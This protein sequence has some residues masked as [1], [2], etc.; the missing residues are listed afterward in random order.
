MITGKEHAQVAQPPTGWQT[1]ADIVFRGVAHLFGAA[2]VLLL[3]AIVFE[4]MRHAGSSM[5]KHRLGFFSG[6]V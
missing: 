2:V 6:S 3:A 5:L 4:V 1:R